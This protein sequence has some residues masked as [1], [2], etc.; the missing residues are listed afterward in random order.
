MV[1]FF[2]IRDGSDPLP[3]VPDRSAAL[4]VVRDHTT[5]RLYGPVYSPQVLPAWEVCFF[6]KCFPFL[7][8]KIL[9]VNTTFVVSIVIDIQMLS[10]SIIPVV[11]WLV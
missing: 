1:S 7:K 9:L 10:L 8:K 5:W 2:W 6:E 4:T 3:P 11:M